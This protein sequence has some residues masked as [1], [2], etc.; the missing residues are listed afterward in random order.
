V[1]DISVPKEEGVAEAKG[2]QAA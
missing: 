1:R 2:G